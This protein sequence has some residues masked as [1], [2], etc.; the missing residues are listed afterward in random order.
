MIEE[1]R[2]NSIR[3]SQAGGA[4]VGV[5]GS[6][7]ALPTNWATGSVSGISYEVIGTGTVSGFSYLDLKISGTNSSG[8]SVNPIFSFEATTVIV[9]SSAQSWTGSCYIALQAGSLAGAS[10]FNIDVTERDSGGAFLA[11]SATGFT[12]TSALT[13]ISHSRTFSNA[14]TAR[15][16]HR[17]HYRDWETDRKSVV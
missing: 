9:A 8:S 13:R 16:N 5:I 12:P 10:S 4:T 6:G 11:A 3:N 1:S 17:A 14:S 2:T 7:G 15:T